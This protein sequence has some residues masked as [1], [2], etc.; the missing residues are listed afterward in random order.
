MEHITHS[1]HR[2]DPDDNSTSE[3]DPSEK[4]DNAKALA[5]PTTHPLHRHLPTL[6][7]LQNRINSDHDI[8]CPT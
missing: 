4:G 6:G 1:E 7:A 3:D 2:E 8:L 5:V